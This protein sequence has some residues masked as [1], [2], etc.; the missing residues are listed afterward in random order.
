M[1][2]DGVGDGGYPISGDPF[3]MKALLL[4]HHIRCCAGISQLDSVNL[5]FLRVLFCL[6]FLF[7]GHFFA[8]FS[9]LF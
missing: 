8:S 2:E 3:L 4:S 9:F 5:P 6:I 7:G 1:I